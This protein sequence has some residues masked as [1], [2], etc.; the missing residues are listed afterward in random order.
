MVLNFCANF[1]Q[2]NKLRWNGYVS[3]FQEN[4]KPILL[5]SRILENKKPRLGGALM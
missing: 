3:K 1:S 4:K 5:I 2:V